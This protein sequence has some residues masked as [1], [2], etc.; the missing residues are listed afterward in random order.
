MLST[1][2]PEFDIDDAVRFLQGH[3]QVGDVLEVRAFEVCPPGTTYRS[4]TYSGYF[5]SSGA[6]IAS[7]TPI[8]PY[9]AGTYV[10]LNPVNPELLA[11]RANRLEAVRKADPLTRDNEVPRRR[12]M[13]LD[14]DPA[15]SAGIP[16]SDGEHEAALERARKVN[17]WLGSEGWPAPIFVDSGNGAHLVY[18]IDLAA[19]DDGLVKAVLRELARTFDDDR[20]HIDQSVH[21]PS[22]LIRLPGTWNRK[23]DS[24][25][26]RP[27]RISRLLEVHK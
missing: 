27:H 23:G 24:T 26:E 22:R 20:V 4:Q 13:L 10:T 21:N 5:D 8:V 9:A 15:R 16:A 3:F 11:R 12:A 17:E 2:S 25:P 14:F 19:D 1:E 18:R 6:I 7:A